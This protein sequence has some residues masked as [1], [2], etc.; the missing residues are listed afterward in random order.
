DRFSLWKYRRIL[1]HT[2]FLPNSGYKDV[3]SVNW[4][5]NDY[6]LGPVYEIEQDL[7]EKHLEGAK[8]LSLSLLYWMQTEAPREGKGYGYP[9]LR[10][11]KDVMGTKD[12]LAKK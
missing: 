2:Q 4:Q 12:G 6:W 10:L 3:T 7:I 9:E 8:Q 5:Q 11:R 1:D